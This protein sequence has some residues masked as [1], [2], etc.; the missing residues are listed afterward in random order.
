MVSDLCPFADPTPRDECERCGGRQMVDV[1]IHGGASLRRDCAICGRFN[2]W[3]R[4]GPDAAALDAQPRPAD[5][6]AERPAKS[7]AGK[8]LF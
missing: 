1:K 7:R 8:T 2:G 4:W 3:A 5:H 6:G